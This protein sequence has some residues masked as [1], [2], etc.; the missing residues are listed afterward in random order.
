MSRSPHFAFPYFHV[1]K[2]ASFPGLWDKPIWGA[3]AWIWGGSG[4]RGA[5]GL[6]VIFLRSAS[7]LGKRL[8]L[9]LPAPLQPSFSAS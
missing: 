9:P 5:P 6:G 2:Q 3:G 1:R 8:F 4:V 7:A